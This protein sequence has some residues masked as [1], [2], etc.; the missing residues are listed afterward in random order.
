MIQW[1]AFKVFLKKAWVWLKHY[2]YFPVMLLIGIVAWC[3]GRRDASGILKMFAKSKESYQKEIGVLKETHDTE[4]K[5][6]D[7]LLKKH[8]ESLKKLEEEYKIKLSDLD[9]EQKKEIG[10]IVEEHKGDPEGLAKRVSDVFGFE[11][12]E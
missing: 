4:I 12:I 6:R 3:A 2:W 11:H 10:K 5:K 8:N 7:D 9:D 1:V